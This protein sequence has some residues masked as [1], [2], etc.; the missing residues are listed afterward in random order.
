MEGLSATVLGTIP[1]IRHNFEESGAVDK[2]LGTA[3]SEFDT[4]RDM[5]E[6]ASTIKY[7][8]CICCFR[9]CYKGICYVGASKFFTPSLEPTGKWRLNKGGCAWKAQVQPNKCCALTQKQKETQQH[10]LISA[11]STRLFVFALLRFR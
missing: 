8:I 5:P 4:M 6:G 10:M 2:E 3:C 1:G 7:N 11:R 9:A